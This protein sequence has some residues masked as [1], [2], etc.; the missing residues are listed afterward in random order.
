M[1]KLK[2]KKMQNRV[3]TKYDEIIRK[4]LFMAKFKGDLLARQMMMKA[5]VPNEIILR[6]MSEQGKIRS[7]DLISMSWK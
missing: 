1:Y 4:G 5:G 7:G 3:N 6:V 2:S